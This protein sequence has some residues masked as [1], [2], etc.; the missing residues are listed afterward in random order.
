[1]SKITTLGQVSE[2]ALL[3]KQY[4]DKAIL[5]IA[6]AVQELADYVAELEGSSASEFTYDPDTET[7]MFAADE[8]ED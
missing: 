3:S 5:L 7:L 4:T 2:A 8:Q 1:M 6:N